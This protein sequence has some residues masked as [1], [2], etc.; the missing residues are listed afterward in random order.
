MMAAVHIQGLQSRNTGARLKHFATNN[1]KTRRSHAREHL[2]NPLV[3][4]YAES[5]LIHDGWTPESIAGSLPLDFP[6][7]ATNAAALALSGLPAGLRKTLTYNK[8]LENALHELTNREFGV[9]SYFCKPRH[10]W[11]KG[12]I[13]NRN[14]ILR[15]YFPKKCD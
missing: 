14:G 5:H 10:S 4:A 6:G 12:S 9:T 2:D 8:G 11:E 3:K 1:Q 15:R 7:L 13:K